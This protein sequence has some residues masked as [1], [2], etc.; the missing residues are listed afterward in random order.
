M[1]KNKTIQ[2]IIVDDEKGCI[3]NLQHY[4]AKLCPDIVVIGTGS[5]L[6]EALNTVGNAHIDVAFLDIEL[7]DDTIFSSLAGLNNINFKIVCVTAHQQYAIKA[8]KAE[9]L[10]Y[11]LKP[12]LEDDILEC[13]S[14]I[15]K[16]F[17]Q[18][19]D[20]SQAAA[21]SDGNKKKIKKL[22]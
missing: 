9:A 7:V 15:K 21:E 17:S 11:I 8:I 5:N 16:H 3:T 4:I 10:D 22:L 18:P 1:E 13:Y 14:K 6:N 20:E 19:Q 2:V 12:L